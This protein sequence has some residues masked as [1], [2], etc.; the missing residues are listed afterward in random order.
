MSPVVTYTL[1]AACGA[2]FVGSFFL[3][4]KGMRVKWPRARAFASALQV[5]AIVAA[6]FVLRP[7]RGD[8][9]R[10]RI[11]ESTAHHAPI[12]LDVYSNY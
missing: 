7:G 4:G 2:V 3:D 12:L 11:A 6:Y 10:A 5:L 1:L 8:D 9:S